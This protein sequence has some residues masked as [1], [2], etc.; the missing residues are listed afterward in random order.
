MVETVEVFDTVKNVEF[1]NF[2]EDKDLPIFKIKEKSVEDWNKRARV[3]N[4]KM[5]VLIHKRQPKN[6]QE[7]LVWIYSDKEKSHCAGDTMTFVN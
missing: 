1:T 2:V 6:Y 4:I 5:F 7:V 3:Q